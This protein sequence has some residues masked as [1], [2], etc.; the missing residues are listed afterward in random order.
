MEGSL[1]RNTYSRPG[2]SRKFQWLPFDVDISKDS[3]DE[4]SSYVDNTHPIDHRG[5]YDT[6]EDIIAK[7]K[8]FGCNIRSNINNVHP[9]EHRG[10]YD[11]VERV[12]ARTIPL[13]DQSLTRR[14]WGKQRIPY[15]DISYGDHIGPE[16]MYPPG[17]MDDDDDDF[18]EDEYQERW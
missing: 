2:L 13:W 3:R 11:A 6:V 12:I 1:A 17:A 10:L 16:P 8:D 7:E 14:P 15:K 18:D 5:L 9:I 4:I